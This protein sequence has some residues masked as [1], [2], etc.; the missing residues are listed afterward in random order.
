MAAAGP[1]D[2][3]AYV[4]PLR[5]SAFGHA[6]ASRAIT[7][8]P[9]ARGLGRHDPGKLLF[10]GEEQGPGVVVV[11]DRLVRLPAEELHR[12]GRPIR[13][14]PMLAR[15]RFRSIEPTT[16]GRAGEDRLIEVLVR[17]QGRDA[18][19][20]S[21]SRGTE[22]AGGVKV[23][24]DRGWITRLSRSSSGSILGPDR[25]GDR[26]EVRD[27]GSTSPDPPSVAGSGAGWPARACGAVGQSR[28]RGK[29]RDRPR[30]TASA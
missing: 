25:L 21:P 10:A 27:A 19:V 9:V 28:S 12:T 16:R 5:L 4:R 6:P 11:E 13:S 24:I 29:R 3:S 14:S 26:D 7:G 30:R 2:A 22:P 15:G 17:D 23:G 8:Q 1:S 20:I 18:E